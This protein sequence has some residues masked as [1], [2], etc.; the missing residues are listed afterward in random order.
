[1]L[2]GMM[3]EL[4]RTKIW[5]ASGSDA[6]ADIEADGVVLGSGASHDLGH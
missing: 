2:H 6:S 1:M 3:A 4:A 5:P